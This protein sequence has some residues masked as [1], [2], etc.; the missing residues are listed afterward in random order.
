LNP[1][2]IIS[3]KL[4]PSTD[5]VLDWLYYH[6]KKFIRM[7]GEDI[8]SLDSDIVLN[9]TNSNGSPEV[10]WPKYSNKLQPLAIWFRRD[11][12]YQLPKELLN[13]IMKD[14]SYDTITN[15]LFQE[16]L[17]GKMA[18]F[19]C[20]IENTRILGNFKRYKINKIEMLLE[21]KKYG[22]GIPA[23]LITNKKAA[24]VDFIEQC[25]NGVI[26]KALNEVITFQ[27]KFDEG[28]VKYASYTE[29]ITPEILAKIPGTFNYSL[30]QEKLDKELDLR[31]FY[32][33][34]KCYSMAIFS[35]NNTQTKVD[36]RKYA[37]NRN[38]PYKL[39]C[40]LEMKIAIFMEKLN[41]N[42]GSLDIVKTKDGKYV[43]LEI[44]P[45]GQYDMTS[46]QCNYY[47]DYM[48]S[49]YLIGEN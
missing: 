43:F 22:I 42:I 46:V 7:N 13:V 12:P 2:I 23:T 19:N 44:N 15:N 30:F 5:K 25:N 9:I 48:I 37:N 31:V 40:C 47:L 36:C 41:I 32:L 35:Q 8:L 27:K 10:S 29:E 28:I 20:L 21:A 49:E 38:V 26:T 14:V 3:T 24:L 11:A 33:D 39:P 1:I 6:G 18:L 4:D 45:F 17:S 34:G 16:L